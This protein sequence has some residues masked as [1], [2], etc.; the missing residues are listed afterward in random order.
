MYFALVEA[1]KPVCSE[2]LHDA[3]VDISVIVLHESFAAHVHVS[4]QRIQVMIEQLLAYFR[5]QVRLGVKQQRSDVVLQRALSPALVIKEVGLP[6]QEHDVAGLKIAI[7]EI[8]AR[9]AQQKLCQAAEI[10][11]QSLFAERYSR[12]SQEVIFEIVQIPGNRLPVE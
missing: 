12:Q 5:R 8:V 10:V 7:E 3:D 9:R 2:R 1:A 4:A 6:V 11:L